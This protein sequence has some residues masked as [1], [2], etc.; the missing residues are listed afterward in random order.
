M[1]PHPLPAEDF[2]YAI[3]RLGFTTPEAS[4]RRG[5]SLA[6]AAHGHH[7]LE[8]IALCS[9]SSIGQPDYTYQ[10]DWNDS[11]A[12]H[13][14]LSRGFLFGQC[15]P[16]LRAVGPTVRRG[17]RQA[18]GMLTDSPQLQSRRRLQCPLRRALP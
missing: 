4:L 7:G 12:R 5:F 8:A 17:G 11:W 14:P 18:A 16:R 6:Q 15:P 9:S 10:Q 1:S 3:G 13:L 2:L